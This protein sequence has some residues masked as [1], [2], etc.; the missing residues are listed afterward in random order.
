MAH[1]APELIPAR[2]GARHGVTKRHAAEAAIAN[3]RHI[4]E[5][6]L[7]SLAASFIRGDLTGNRQYRRLQTSF[8]TKQLK[9]PARATTEPKHS[10]MSGA[11]AH[12]AYIDAMLAPS[13][14]E[15]VAIEAAVFWF[16]GETE[17]HADDLEG[18]RVA[19]PASYDAL[20]AGRLAT[21]AKH[22]GRI[23]VEV[24]LRR[25]LERQARL[26][27]IS[28]AHALVR[29]IRRM[30]IEP[31]GRR[32]S[33]FTHWKTAGHILL[34]TVAG[35]ASVI[36][37]FCALA[38]GP[39][40]DLERDKL[41]G[42]LVDKQLAP[43]S[44]N[45]AWLLNIAVNTAHELGPHASRGQIAAAARY[46]FDAVGSAAAMDSAS[47]ADLGLTQMSFVEWRTGF[48]ASEASI[49][50]AIDLLRSLQAVPQMVSAILAGESPQLKPSIPSGRRIAYSSV[51]LRADGEP[52]KEA[53]SLARNLRC[54]GGL[55]PANCSAQKPRKSLN[56]K[57]LQ[58]PELIANFERQF[59]ID[60]IRFFQ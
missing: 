47:L 35:P 45:G 25:V 52:D 32:F 17:R 8:E 43:S 48:S 24:D 56:S 16:D 34:S 30:A 5:T 23:G 39:F 37:H 26:L 1:V 41:P 51:L 2:Y 19:A 11:L 54:N 59:A 38:A 29:A 10:P 18:L 3:I 15:D 33:G 55:D 13:G 20:L 50:V 60:A 12:L 31:H 4:P 40:V 27:I 36:Q 46:I 6:R 22:G 58:A 28:R 49:M 42:L 53:L 7:A 14:K 9:S 44:A 21:A 57:T